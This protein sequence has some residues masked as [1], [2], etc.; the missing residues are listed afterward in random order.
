MGCPRCHQELPSAARFCP[1]CGAGAESSPDG[2]LNPASPDQLQSVLDAIARTAAQLCGARDALIFRAEGD[3]CRRVTKYGTLR[4]QRPLGEPEPITRHTPHGRAILGRRLIHIRDLA[5]V[6]R[7]GVSDVVELHHVTGARTALVAPL[8]SGGTAKPIDRDRLVAAL[9][10][11]RHGLSVLVV[12]DDEDLR[13]LLR[14]ILEKE[15]FA[16]SQAGNGRAGLARARE[17]PPGLILLDLMMPEMDGFEFVAEL[18]GQAWGRSIPII[19][20]TAMELTPADR[21]RLNGGVQRILQKGRYR[22]EALLAEVRD[23][24]AASVASRRIEP[25]H[26][27][28]PGDE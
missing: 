15:G 22:R 2:E 17:A 23:M 12:E 6:A 11:Y 19:V 20:V 5:V 27:A 24:V 16:V 7:R 4:T 28:A 21:E 10:P 14:R 9:A 18:R 25:A 1:S 3:V 26:E 8:L 13:S